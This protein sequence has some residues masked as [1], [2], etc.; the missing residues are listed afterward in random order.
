M[1]ALLAR[2]RVTTLVCASET[3]ARK[4]D[5]G[6]VAWWGLRERLPAR[7]A[8]DGDGMP[9]G[10]DEAQAFAEADLPGFFAGADFFA[11]D[12]PLPFDAEW[13]FPAFAASLSFSTSGVFSHVKP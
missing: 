7:V 4:S 12:L 6:R 8:V 10:L 5:R 2:S 11:A 1:S 13:P 3:M 9:G